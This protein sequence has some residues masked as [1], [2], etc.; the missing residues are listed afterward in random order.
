M[1]FELKGCRKGEAYRPGIRVGD[2]ALLSDGTTIEDVVHIALQDKRR[3]SGRGDHLSG[4]LIADQETGTLKGC[5]F[6]H[7]TG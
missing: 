4:K 1:A 7:E 5:T 3:E 6:H 2:T